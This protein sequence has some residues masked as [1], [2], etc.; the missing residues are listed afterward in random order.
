MRLQK[1][2]RFDID[3]GCNESA[4]L[5]SS[6]MPIPRQ[7][8][9]KE[10]A[11]GTIIQPRQPGDA[12]HLPRWGRLE[13]AERFEQ[14][15]ELQAQGLS[16]RQAA[17]KLAVPRST[18]QAWQASQARLD[19][20]PAVV[21]FL[22]SVPG[23]ACLHRLVLGIPL[24]GTEGGACGIRLGGLLMQLTGLDRVV[25]ASYGAQHQGNRP[26][27]EA[28][29][30]YRRAE[31]TR[32]A[33]ERPA[34]DLTVAQD[35]TCTGGLGLVAM[36]PKSTSMLLEQAAQARD[37]GTW[38]AL[39]EQ[40][41]SGLHGHILPSTSDE[42]PALLAYVEHAL[43]AHH[44]PDVLHGQHELVKAVSGPRATK[45]RAAGK[46]ATE[47]HKRLEQGRGQLQ[48]A[49]GEPQQHG[50]GHPPKDTARLEQL[51]QEAA[52]ARQEPQRISAQRAQVAQR[53]RTLG[54]AYHWVD[55]ERGVRRNGKRMAAAIHA[56]SDPVRTVAPHEGLSQTCLERIEQAERVLPNMQAPIEL[57]SGYVRQQGAPLH[58]TPPVSYALHAPLL[59]S[60]SLERVAQ[61]RTVQAG[62]PL[63]EVAERL[64]T[65]LYEPGGALAALSEAEH[66]A[67]Q[68]Q[69]QALAEG[70]Q[71]SSA[72]V[73]GRN[74]SLSLR[75]HQLRG[76][77]RPRK[78]A[79]LTAVH[80]LLLTRPDGTPA[81]ERFFGKKPRSMCPAILAS[82]AIPPAPLSPP[83]R[84][85]G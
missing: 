48:S 54:Q 62:E 61:T 37:Q 45:P 27:E 19:E 35:E 82:V 4:P 20:S 14:S 1:N 22:Q 67:R 17:Q 83:R 32:W 63:R 76:L 12:A 84:A 6:A 79:C 74:G 21:A 71:R 29:V 78:R 47:A 57:V 80:N 5:P 50:P 66:S 73:E 41:L 60:C 77:D 68:Q 10:G 9:N 81:A 59:P 33:K 8:M 3:M 64:R 52:V 13:R 25:A 70:F 39:M 11:V 75:H 44:S 18:L 15:L 72:N 24:G 58:G 42:A 85:V 26:V 40:A 46:A 7:G 43:G 49:G 65:P 30:A 36:D 53:L 2:Q 56:Q 34:Q 51:A 69:A 55:L 38:H 28:I 16:Q 31:S 23:L